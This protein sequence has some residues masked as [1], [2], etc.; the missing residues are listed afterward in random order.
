MLFFF[1]PSNHLNDE[2]KKKKKGKYKQP[3]EMFRIAVSR[4][5][6]QNTYKLTDSKT[7]LESSGRP[8]ASLKQNLLH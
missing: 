5:S 8:W 3:K 7:D 4:P 1:L 2:Q 6:I